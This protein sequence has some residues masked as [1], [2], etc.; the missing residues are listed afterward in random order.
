MRWINIID[1]M[2][3]CGRVVALWVAMATGIL[4]ALGQRVIGTEGLL[5]VPSADMRPAGTFDGGACLLQN[6]MMMDAYDY[7][8]GLYYI[9]FTPFSF[10]EVTFRETLR[11]TRKSRYDSRLG[12]YQQDRSTSVRV[13]PLRERD[14]GWWP[15]LVIGVND[16]YSDHGAS[17]YAAVYGVLTK[18][19]SMGRG[20]RI[21]VTAGYA[22]P[23][24]SGSV[25]DGVFGGLSWSPRSSD[26]LKV[27]AE[28][29]TR[30]I[31]VGASVLLMRH[32]QVMCFTREFEGVCGGL[33][34][35]Y[36]IKY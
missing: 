26:R 23:I 35:L 21:G 2:T 33:S 18:N 27:I 10:V 3:R 6:R 19:V 25:Y 7:Y 13:R 34:Y 1:I 29:D 36:T 9:D 14:G 8:T 31:N 22:R 28:Y 17:E 5:N 15:G 30:G 24:D 32:L 12:F 4:T 16:I 11:K 20:G